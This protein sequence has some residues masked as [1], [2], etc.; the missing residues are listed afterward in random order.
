MTLDISQK[1]MDLIVKII[2]V[3]AD[4]CDVLAFGSRISGKAKSYSDLDLAFVRKNGEK[5]G[6]SRVGE[7]KFVFSASNI[8]FI[9][10]VIDYN[11]ASPEFKAI[12]DKQ[13]ISLWRAET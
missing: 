12:I 8:P 1:D 9:V 3:F 6:F 7:I 4:D 5:L 11:A 13:N 2:R 10:D